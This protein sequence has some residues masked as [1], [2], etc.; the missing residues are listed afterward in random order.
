[1]RVRIIAGEFG[2]RRIHAPRNRRTHPMSERARGALFNSIFEEIVGA[3]VL[4]AFAGTG[5]IGLEALSRGA[6]YV[7]L[8]EKDRTAAKVIGQNIDT[9][10]LDDSR[11]KLVQAPVGSWS[12]NNIDTE[13]DIIFADPPYWDIQLSTVEKLFRHLKPDGLMVLS[14]SGRGEDLPEAKGIVVVDVRSYSGANLAFFRR[15]E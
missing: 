14:Y 2:G 9:L 3:N 11:I 8:V 15:E 13:F 7:T 1:M 6:K 4:D 12:G 5:A 10:R